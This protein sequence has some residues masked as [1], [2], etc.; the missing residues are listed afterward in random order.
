MRLHGVG[1]VFGFPGLLLGDLS[2]HIIQKPF[3][4][5]DPHSGKFKEKIR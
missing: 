2:Y 4:F 5:I 3:F 1:E